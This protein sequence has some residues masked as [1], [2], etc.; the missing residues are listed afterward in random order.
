M[1]TAYCGPEI[2]CTLRVNCRLQTKCKMNTAD[3][4]LW[5]E[6]K[7]QTVVTWYMLKIS[8]V[9]SLHFTLSLMSK[10]CSPQSAFTMTIQRMDVLK[11]GEEERVCNRLENSP[12]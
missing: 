2:K 4:I 8:V 12:L 9:C 7:M 3:Y 6:H 5:T 10:V 11:K 1:K